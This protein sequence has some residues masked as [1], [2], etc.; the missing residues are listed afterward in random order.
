MIST[1]IGHSL[2]LDGE[3]NVFG[4]GRSGRFELCKRVKSTKSLVPIKL[5]RIKEISA[6]MD[7]LF[8]DY[9]GRVWACGRSENGQLGLGEAVDVC[10]NA[11]V[12]ISTLPPVHTISTSCNY[13]SAFIDFDGNVWVCGF[14][15]YGQLGNDDASHIPILLKTL[16]KIRAISLGMYHTLFLDCDGFVWSAGYNDCGQLGHPQFEYNQLGIHTKIPDLKD[17]VAVSAGENHSLFLDDRGCVWGAGSNACGQIG[18]E[19]KGVWGTHRNTKLPFIRSIYAGYN[20]SAFIDEQDCVW[21]CGNDAQWGFSA[22]ALHTPRKLSHHKVRDLCL[23]KDHCL[24]LDIAGN[25]WGVGNNETGALGG[26]GK[27]VT[28]FKPT[29]IPKL[30]LIFKNDT[31]SS[32][33]ARKT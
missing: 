7:S 4:C 16:P 25:V 22:N 14:N 29:K 5:S 9:D 23:G 17:I 18:D 6:G 10:K 15:A 19:K 20:T 13:Y 32:K 24:L 3:G 1:G 11:P 21:T 12:Q 8:L 33:S 28:L 26:I 2:F 31:T 30:P 27:P